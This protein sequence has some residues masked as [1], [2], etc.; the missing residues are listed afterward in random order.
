MRYRPPQAR[1]PNRSRAKP[2]PQRTLTE[3]R[4]KKKIELALYQG[5]TSVVP[6]TIRLWKSF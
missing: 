6:I 2:S 5:T 4:G 3:F 1:S